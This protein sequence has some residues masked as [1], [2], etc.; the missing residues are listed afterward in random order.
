[1]KYIITLIMALLPLPLLAQNSLAGIKRGSYF[2]NI[3]KI[4]AKDAIEYYKWD[5]IPVSRFENVPVF[6]TCKTGYEDED[7]L[8]LGFYVFVTVERSYV[9]TKIFNKTN[10]AV[11]TVNNRK[12]LQLDIRT[13]KGEPVA[14]ASV[15]VGKKKAI[16]NTGSHTFWVKQTTFEENDVFVYSPGD[17]MI[18]T[19]EAL[20]DIYPSVREQKRRKFRSSE[21]YGI[22]S[23]VPRKAR[24]FF[25]K[26]KMNSRSRAT[27]YVIFNKP[28]YKPLDTVKFK[29]YIIDRKWKRYEK[30]IKVRLSYYV[31]GN[32]QVVPL[33]T[34]KA[35]SPGAYTNSFVLGDSI[36]TDTRG[37]L[38][39]LDNDEKLLVKEVFSLEE[40]VLD[41]IGS[42]SFT[43]DKEIYY[44]NDSMVFKASA[45]DANGL[46]VMDATARLVLTVNKIDTFFK[47]RLLVPDTI[48]NKEVKLETATETRFVVPSGMMPAANIDIIARLV[49]KN[50]NNELQQ[51]KLDIKYLFY[52]KKLLVKE[53]DDS[54]LV[55]Y[56]QDGYEQAAKGTMQMNDDPEEEVTYPLAIKINPRANDYSFD[57]GSGSNY[58]YTYHEVEESYKVNFMR[59]SKMDTLGFILT[60]P[61]KIPVYYTVLDGDKVVA[62]GSSDE[63]EIIWKRVMGNKRQAYNIRWQYYWAGEEEHGQETI[64]LLYKI[65]TIG[66]DGK[67]KIF[68]GESDSLKIRIT[69]Y[70]G[71]P[72]SNVN[73]TAVS[74][75][76][77]FKKDARLKE[78]PYLVKYKFKRG[79]DRD[80]FENNDFKPFI[81]N[82]GYALGK[83][84]S[85]IKN[86]SLDSMEYYKLLFPVDHYYD[87]MRYQANAL[88]PQLAVHAVDKGDPQEIY[89]LYINNELVYYNGVTDRMPYSFR[90]WP[91]NVKLGIRLKDR[92]I[93]IDS[94]YIQPNYKHDISFDI[95]NLPPHSKEYKRDNWWSQYEMNAIEQSMFMIRVN[96]RNRSWLWQDDKLVSFPKDASGTRIA[97]PFSLNQFLTYFNEKE[98]DLGF[99][100]EPGYEYNLS[101]QILRLE[102]KQL[103]ND[104]AKKN[105]LPRG[106]FW[107]LV[108]GDTLKKLPVIEYPTPAI[109]KNPLLVSDNAFMFNRN[110][111]VGDHGEILLDYHRDSVIK[112]I[113]LTN[114]L[115]QA[116]PAVIPFA[117]RMVHN[118]EPGTYNILLVNNYDQ[119]HTI[120]NVTIKANTTSCIKIPVLLNENNNRVLKEL[121][122]KADSFYMR[123]KQA[124]EE[125]L[126]E[127][128]QTVPVKQYDPY[129]KNGGMVVGQVRDVQ[130][131]AI[132]FASVVVKGGGGVQTDANGNYAIR[133]QEFDEAILFSALGYASIE[134]NVSVKNGLTR[135][136]D[137]SLKFKENSIAE[138]VV[139]SAFNTRRAARSTGSILHVSAEE[140]TTA[141]ALNNVLA[142]K[143][144]GVRVRSAA[145]FFTEGNV[146]I[147]GE[148]SYT[149]NDIVYVVD[150]IIY[151]TEQKIEAD[152]IDDVKVLSGPEAA[153][154]FGPEAGNGAIVITTKRKTQRKDFRDY[155]FWEPDFFTDKNGEAA[156]K[157]TYP[158]NITSWKTFVVGMDKNNRIGKASTI[159]QSYKPMIG[160]LNLPLFLVEGDSSRFVTKSINY[161][162]DNYSIKTVF[163]INDK[164]SSENQFDLKGNDAI[165]SEQ[166]V[167]ASGDTVT[168]SFSMAST[169]GFKD[170]EERKIPVYKKGMEQAE[171]A[172][173]ILRKDTAVHFSA[174]QEAGELNIYA[175]NNTLDVLLA[176]LD[177][178]K[179]Y[180]YFCVEQMTSK[181]RGLAMEKQIREVL[182]QPFKAQKEM[183]VLL[184]KIQKA[185]LFDGGWPWWEGGKANL[186]ISNYI[187]TALL[188]L[189]NA[190]LVESNV[191]NGLLYLQGKL[192]SLG[193]EDLLAT[194]KTLSDAK[195]EMNYAGWLNRIKFDSLSQHQ[196]WQWVKIMQQQKLDYKKQLNYLLSKKT[197]T[198]HGGIHW[199]ESNYSWYANDIATTII[200]MEVLK[201]EQGMEAAINSIIQYFLEMKRGGY[202][203]NTVESATILN[204]VLPV[205]L[206]DQ[207]NFSSN[208]SL[209]V[210]SDTS[211]SIVKFP[212]QATLNAAEVKNI[213]IR[214]QGG[215]IVYF[216]AYQNWFNTNP[217]PDSNHFV[218][219]T[220]FEKNGK[221]V[222]EIQSGEK[223][224]MIVKVKVLKDAEYVMITMP[225]PAGCIFTD[226][227]NNYWG[228]H[229][230]YYKDRMIMYAERL[231]KGEYNFEASLEPR[232]NGLYHLNPAKAE[233]MYYPVFSGNNEM[234]SVR[235]VSP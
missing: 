83:N 210:T 129:I 63:E 142:G 122:G 151:N 38:E 145:S 35:A 49:F 134:V 219:Q 104:K 82:K 72:A 111:Q 117:Y 185:Q 99:A 133:V 113:I 128:L 206:E 110:S 100:F 39:F 164:I 30:A 233:L 213:N 33:Y 98:F 50:S 153:A 176:E 95:N 174:R 173:F 115:R 60:N 203:R 89:L 229:K 159:T 77:Q 86:F 13:M 216:T 26:K 43:A 14:N 197:A 127:Q 215:G 228:S 220:M 18:T 109:K 6:K 12:K 231:E 152:I 131:A 172:F 88:L 188:P 10:L 85:W 81:L 61:Y 212:Y 70:K 94:L 139:T 190:P 79:I 149:A 132:P 198:M 208:A 24:A 91:Q 64:G 1:M 90:V 189:R 202:W 62:T 28:K 175:Q 8:P 211:F 121:Q 41:E 97:G 68:P 19:V 179:K 224:K 143:V 92:Y 170:M 59:Y 222:L 232:Y 161:T 45:K 196:Q 4:S 154:L 180:P 136:M 53:Q 155:A 40:Y 146:R 52:S 193:K 177:Q 195:H 116:E 118:I 46:Y 218:I 182:N 187:T 7:L 44:K 58:I 141:T 32:N 31:R 186:Q 34:I 192:P 20:G 160:Q 204:A 51:K 124:V 75:N 16:Y 166:P 194:L 2:T 47:D 78:P 165:I 67:Q 69:D 169:T 108:L 17:T 73:L 201:N 207:K 106:S 226:K 56:L 101:K 103:F 15:F 209:L 105:Y 57:V 120:F 87:A 114:Q 234:R 55:S 5:S 217:V 184:K 150:G 140:L 74:Y 130:G 27:G 135:R 9:K 84:K 119:V 66:I 22:V 80:V 156:I 230:E 171:G 96:N 21:V 157:V 76:N 178:L 23:W 112:Y 223:V 125:K 235:I 227:G 144:S 221:E 163:K 71:R 148:N 102:K 138:V 126:A 25:S 65:L 3:Y 199:G 225:I 181:F 48:Y 123:E 162:S 158:D 29:V 147:R 93:E 183:D 200:A 167:T 205:L 107:G 214:K 191:R 11:L 37:W 42:Q 36:P 137:V 168:T 54:L